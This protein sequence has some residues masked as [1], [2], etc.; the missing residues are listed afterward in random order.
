MVVKIQPQ[1]YDILNK[2]IYV[3]E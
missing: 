2:I 1:V 3:W